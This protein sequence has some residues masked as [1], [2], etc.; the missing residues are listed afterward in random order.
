MVIREN[1]EI[2]VV[3]CEVQINDVCRCVND[4]I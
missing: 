4:N 2:T 3:I 1:Y